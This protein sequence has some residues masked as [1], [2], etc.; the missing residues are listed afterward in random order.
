MPKDGFK[1]GIKDNKEFAKLQQYLI[2][3]FNLYR[4]WYIDYLS[5]A[6]YK[7]RL[8]Y[9]DLDT[10]TKE[11]KIMI[12]FKKFITNGANGNYDDTVK[13]IVEWLY[14]YSFSGDEPSAYQYF[15]L[16]DAEI[17]TFR[18]FKPL[19][20]DA[21]IFSD[22]LADSIIADDQTIKVIVESRLS[23]KPKYMTMIQ[24]KILQEQLKTS[25]DKKPL[26]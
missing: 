11:D 1:Y 26:S 5:Y 9:D 20:F 22:Q 12:P 10:Q 4:R 18:M 8:Y 24:S 16:P 14:W 23:Y 13:E 7:G 6:A 3:Q 15:G 19:R 2:D 21:K 25:Y 17:A